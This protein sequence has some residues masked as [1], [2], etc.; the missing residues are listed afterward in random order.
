MALMQQRLLRK[1]VVA[2]RLR[3]ACT[4]C[5]KI[6]VMGD[7]VKEMLYVTMGK[8][9]F[10]KEDGYLPEDMVQVALDHLNSAELLFLNGSTVHLDSAGF[11]AHLGLEVLLKALILDLNGS[12]PDSHSIKFLYIRGKG[13]D[14][15]FKID[16]HYAPLL[17]LID[18][19]CTG[20][21]YPNRNQPVP[22]GKVDWEVFKSIAT[23]IQIQ[24][25][26]PL[27]DLTTTESNVEKTGRIIF[28]RKS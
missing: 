8:R 16:E 21:R 4:S 10:S 13:L 6:C 11:L 15:S 9:Q 18:K 24:L 19:Q 26:V 17:D 1:T 3:V 23:Q 28:R 2:V 12:F 20:L 5:A 27:C 22:I 25:R 14:E 7:S